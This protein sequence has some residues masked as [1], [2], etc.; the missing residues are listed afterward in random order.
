MLAGGRGRFP[1][2]PITHACDTGVNGQVAEHHHLSFNRHS[3][4][5]VPPHRPRIHSKS[6]LLKSV[7]RVSLELHLVHTVFGE[8]AGRPEQHLYRWLRLPRGSRGLASGCGAASMLPSSEMS[9]SPRSLDKFSKIP[10]M[11]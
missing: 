8:N 1:F 6:S 11:C 4:A 2:E 10:S 9:S 5:L 7:R 3:A